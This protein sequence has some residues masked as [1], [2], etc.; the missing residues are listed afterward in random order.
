MDN[1][2]LEH[3]IRDILEAKLS[4]VGRTEDP[5]PTEDGSKLRRHAEIKTKIIDE[6]KKDDEEEDKKAEAEKED[7]KADEKEDKK[8]DKA[9]KKNSEAGKKNED[10][11]TGEKTEVETEPETNDSKADGSEDKK[12]KKEKDKKDMKESAM[13]RSDKTFGLPQSLIDVVAEALKGK[14]HKIDKNK[15]GKIDAEDF[16]LLRKEEVEIEEADHQS[17]R[18]INNFIA[19]SA[20]ERA[21]NQK[22][23]AYDKDGK[24]VGLYR[25][26]DDA[27]RLKPGH[28]Y[29]VHNE[30]VDIEVVAEED[31]QADQLKKQ[32]DAKKDQLAKQVAQKKM[33]V[34]QQKAQKQM[35]SMKAEEVTLS[36]DEIA[37]LTEINDRTTEE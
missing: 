2:S 37:R 4:I 11:I 6:A 34:M 27:K 14:Q 1:K 21:K 13:L 3:K 9:D 8:E 32:L 5:A 20:S 25:N 7:S 24:P 16:E 28:T 31:G 18:T 29:K 23:A 17:R 12:D 35:S 33:Q 15:N 10:K 30:E 22:V 36:D 26:M 19:K